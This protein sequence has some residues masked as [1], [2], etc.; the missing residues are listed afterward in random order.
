MA[1]SSL[2]RRQ[3]VTALAAVAVVPALPGRML[4]HQESSPEAAGG[5][6]SLG[7]PVLAI[8]AGLGSIEASSEITAGTTLVQVSSE[9]E[10]TVLLVQT[11]D[12]VTDADLD[13]AVVSPEM[14]EFLFESVVA[15]SFEAAPG[16]SA[17]QA[18]VLEAGEWIV[19]LSAYDGSGAWARITVT[20]DPVIVD[21]PA[22]V[23]VEMTHHA[24]EVPESVPA[25]LQTWY[26]VNV[27]PM[28]HHMILF[29]YPEPWTTD[30]ALALLM[31]GEGMASPPAGLDPNLMGY[32]GGIGIISEGR[33]VWQDLDLAPG[34]YA[35]VCF[36]A[37]PG[38]DVPHVMQGMISVF[39]AE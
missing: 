11:P 14:P 24:F 33:A 7:L 30:D 4:A 31:A 39:T 26:L 28:L 9:V 12:T 16:M 10:G 29:S 1:T 8:T 37:D 32:A 3:L 22:A 23:E 19:A 2:N 27:D 18:V 38:S 36:I 35:A 25:G 34:N 21:I 17:E 6:A 13:A 20:G 5:L 15:S